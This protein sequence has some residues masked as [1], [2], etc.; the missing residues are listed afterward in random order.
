M[1]NCF[2]FWN[3]VN[4]NPTFASNRSYRSIASLFITEVL[5]FR[6]TPVLVAD[7]TRVEVYYSWLYQLCEHLCHLLSFVK[8][9][10]K[11]MF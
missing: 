6:S 11:T 8:F 4:H 10:E 1:Q 2:V 9:S 7:S 5:Y 3:P